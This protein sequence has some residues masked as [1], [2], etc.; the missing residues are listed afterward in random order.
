MLRVAC[1]EEEE[2]SLLAERIPA[3][4]LQDWG[5]EVLRSI[6]DQGLNRRSLLY[7]LDRQLLAHYL[8]PEEVG[9]TLLNSW[10]IR[11]CGALLNGP[12]P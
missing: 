1:N 5:P 8:L 12:L 9:A 2:F 3:S 7:D 4:T 11:Q 6:L 10:G